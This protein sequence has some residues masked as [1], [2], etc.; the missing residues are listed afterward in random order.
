MEFKRNIDWSL[1]A[2]DEV[3]LLRLLQHPFKRLRKRF[4]FPETET[5]AYKRMNTGKR[6]ARVAI[7]R[8][9]RVI[10]DR[11]GLAVE[12]DILA[13]PPDGGGYLGVGI[14]GNPL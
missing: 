7:N 12:V 4:I 3:V 11:P 13:H 8:R 5:I 6:V 10:P 2:F 1:Q 9:L 14:F